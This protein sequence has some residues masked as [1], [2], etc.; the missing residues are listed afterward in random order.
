MK[1]ILEGARNLKYKT[2]LMTIYS[3]GC[4]VTEAAHLKV[5][6][7]DSQRMQIRINQGK[8]K[9]DRYTI[10]SKKLLTTLR[11]YWKCYRPAEWLFAGL[12][13]CG[14]IGESAIQKEFKDVK[15]KF[16]Y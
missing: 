2:I 13:K 4:R 7:I 10:L 9:K 6:D 12:G 11:E 5:S 15:K 8:G 3:T 1:S 14:P 16:A